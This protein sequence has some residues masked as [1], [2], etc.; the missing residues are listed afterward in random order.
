MLNLI[1]EQDDIDKIYLYAK[2]LSE[3]KYEFLIKKREDVGI[4]YC[5]DPNAFIEC[6][7]RMDDVY[8]NIDDYS[9]RRKRKILIVFDDM[10]AD[11][12]SNKAFQAII[13]EL[14][15]ICRKLNISLVFITQSYFSVPKNVRLNSTHLIMKINNRKELQN[16]AIN[17]SADIDYNNFVRIYRECIRKPYSFLTIDTT[18]PASDPLKI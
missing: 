11:I 17:H 2:D 13:K 9:L 14:F 15:I 10:I 5:N 7:N 1:K 4:K 16:I 6:S 3:P 8:Q 12:M 18:L